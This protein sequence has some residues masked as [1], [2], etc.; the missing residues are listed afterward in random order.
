MM[1][2]LSLSSFEMGTQFAML[3]AGVFGFVEDTRSLRSQIST[4]GTKSIKHTRL[5]LHRKMDASSLPRKL[6]MNVVNGPVTCAIYKSQA[7]LN[8]PNLCLSQPHGLCKELQRKL[9]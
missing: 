9:S 4:K 2:S 7:H 3:G 5:S 8:P 1:P 6:G